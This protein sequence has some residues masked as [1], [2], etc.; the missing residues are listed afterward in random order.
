MSPIRTRRR[1]HGLEVSAGEQI[2]VMAELFD[3]LSDPTRL[4]LLVQLRVNDAAC[5][6]DLALL[7]GT[8]ESAVS[9][10]LRLLRAHGIVD[11]ERRGRRIFYTLA[12][13]RARVVIDA[14]IPHLDADRR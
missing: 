14:A 7:T 8:S 1:Q 2:V 6:S 13:P 5:V 10:A 12:D 3:M 4:R 11:S 9:H